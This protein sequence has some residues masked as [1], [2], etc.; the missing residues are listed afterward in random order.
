MKIPARYDRR[1][2]LRGL[3]AGVGMLP[4][5]ESEWARAGCVPSPPRRFMAFVFTNGAT[6]SKFWPLTTGAGYTLNEAT[7]PLESV[8]D[9]I[10][11][12]NG[13]QFKNAIDSPNNVS[14]HH[15]L[16]VVLTG[17]PLLEHVHNRAH[18]IAGGPSIEH[19][20]VDEVRKSKPQ[21]PRPLV[22][23][24]KPQREPQTSW[25]G[26]RAPESAQTDLYKVFNDLFMN[27]GGTAVVPAADLA[28]LRAARKSMLDLVGRD[29]ER[30]CKNLGKDDR[31]RCGS[32]LTSFREVEKD[33]GMNE[34]AGPAGS[35][36]PPRL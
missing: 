12:V 18:A 10:T 32:H 23:A 17:V 3:G 26:A 25:R 13:L 5:L 19:Y 36:A 4:M 20:I 24:Y 33:F 14:G 30:F 34:Q 1:L 9:K 11:F 6:N 8:K 15:D 29:I 22:I 35:C 27:G 28:R 2:F 16:P 7:A 31:A 21:E